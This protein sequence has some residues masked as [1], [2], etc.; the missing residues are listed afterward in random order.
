MIGSAA[1]FIGF[2]LTDSATRSKKKMPV[3]VVTNTVSEKID[4]LSLPGA[5]VIVRRMNY[6][7][8]LKR[9]NM[10]TKFLMSSDKNAKDVQG[11]ID[12]QTEEVA[13]WDFANLV[14][15][16]NLTD[17]NDVPLNFKSRQHVAM[18]DGSIGREVGTI[19]DAFNGVKDSEEVKNS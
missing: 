5:Y 12:M 1:S 13:Y 11:E 18:L 10:A 16:H 17:A 19:I 8:E 14:V 15:E 4:L 2:M 6:G 9:S 7:E 3:A